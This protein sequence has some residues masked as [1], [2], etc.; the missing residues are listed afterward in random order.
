MAQPYERVPNTDQESS[1]KDVPLRQESNPRRRL[2]LFAV[3]VIVVAFAS[4]KAG[5]WW[6]DS[7]AVRSPLPHP[8][9]PPPPT[10][11]IPSISPVDTS[12]PIPT[13]IPMHEHGKISVG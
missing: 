5:Q 4:F 1:I 8:P 11:I 2:I 13:D 9:P 6:S 12:E 3:S 10:S 7:S